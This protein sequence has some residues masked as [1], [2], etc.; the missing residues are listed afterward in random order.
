MNT[1]QRDPPKIVERDILRHLVRHNLGRPGLTLMP[2]YTPNDWWECDL[3]VFSAARY[4]TEYEIKVTLSD[5]RA[6]QKK[7]RRFCRGMEVP[8]SQKAYDR[9]EQQNPHLYQR[10][11]KHGQAQEGQGPKHFWFCAPRGVIPLE[12]LPDWAGLMEFEWAAHWNSGELYLRGR[13]VRRAPAIRGARKFEQG[14]IDHCRGV[15]YYRL[16]NQIAGT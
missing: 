10:L 16:L 12:E 5:F 2:H 3:A 7:S 1:I 15:A 8:V 9:L 14:V 4:L 13:Q 6:D 11:Y